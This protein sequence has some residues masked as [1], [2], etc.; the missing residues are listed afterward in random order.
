MSFGELVAHEIHKAFDGAIELHEGD[1]HYSVTMRNETGEG[2]MLFYHVMPG[3][4][5][6]YCNFSLSLIHI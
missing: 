4:D 6:A 3:V 5:L 1:G 2:S